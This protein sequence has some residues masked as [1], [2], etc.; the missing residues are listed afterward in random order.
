MIIW[1]IYKKW[2]VCIEN[3][4][5]KYVVIF[6]EDNVPPA[7]RPMGKSIGI[8]P[9]KGGIVLIVTVKTTLVF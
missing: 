6:K 5:V 8:H 2:T 1:V 3:F 4:K 9:G 7:V